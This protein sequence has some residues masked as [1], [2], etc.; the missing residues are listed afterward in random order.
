MEDG[1]WKMR[2]GLAFSGRAQN[3]NPVDYDVAARLL[4][5]LRPG[6]AGEWERKAARTNKA[7]RFSGVV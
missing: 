7:S 6:R 5:V 1:G 3:D 4:P 2:R